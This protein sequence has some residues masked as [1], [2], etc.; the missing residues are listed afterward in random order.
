[1]KK[2]TKKIYTLFL[3]MLVLSGCSSV[4]SL[5]ETVQSPFSTKIPQSIKDVVASKVNPETQIYALGSEKL[6][7]SGPIVAQSSANKSASTSIR[8]EAKRE[9]RAIFNEYLNTMDPFS[10]SVVRP[11]TGDLTEYSV[12]LIM[13]KVTQKGAWQDAGRVYSLLVLDKSE[14]RPIAEK[15][16]KNFVVNA[17]SNLEKAGGTLQNSNSSST[18]TRPKSN[19]FSTD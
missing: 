8:N 14:I 7:E 12:S 19:S 16:L 5:F 1:M 4:S 13:K 6:R 2:N 15:V 17:A 18:N 9:V 11:A 3:G 10:K